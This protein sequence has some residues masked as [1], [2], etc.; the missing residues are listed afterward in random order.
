MNIMDNLIWREDFNVN[1]RCKTRLKFWAKA[2]ENNL[3]KRDK[4]ETASIEYRNIE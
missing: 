1:R 3:N 2:K 4:R